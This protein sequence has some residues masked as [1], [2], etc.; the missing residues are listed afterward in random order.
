MNAWPANKRNPLWVPSDIEGEGGA[1]KS[2]KIWFDISHVEPTIIHSNTNQEGFLFRI[3]FLINNHLILYY[4]SEPMKAIDV[5]AIGDYKIQVIFDDNISGIVDLEYLT[6]KGI[7][8]ELSDPSLF[9]KVYTTGEA[10]AWS[11][12]LEIDALNI[13]AKIVNKNP[14][15][16]GKHFT[17]ATN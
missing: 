9:A 10:I 13:Y 14:S 16:L 11:D 4:N 7:F 15:E 8:R 1:I 12:E 2:S 6:Q 3:L 17:H 5:K